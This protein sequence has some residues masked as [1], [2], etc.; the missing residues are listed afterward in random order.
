MQNPRSC[1]NCASD[2]VFSFSFSPLCVSRQ[3]AEIRLN[4]LLGHWYKILYSEPSQSSF[5]RSILSSLFSSI[6][7]ASVIA[8]TVTVSLWPELLNMV[9]EV[10]NESSAL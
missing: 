6:M 3:I 4:W 10:V 1:K 8:D 5:K 9:A 2:L 7:E